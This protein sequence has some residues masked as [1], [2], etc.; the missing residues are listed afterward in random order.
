MGGVGEGR[1][2]KDRGGDA[3][4]RAGCGGQES[5]RQHGKSTR[6]EARGLGGGRGRGGDGRAELN[7]L[8][9]ISFSKVWRLQV[10]RIRVWTL[11]TR[12]R[13]EGLGEGEGRGIP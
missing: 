2:G 10:P 12:Y 9:T 13:A 3:P 1:P 4:L 8:K 6:P 5:C 11:R 7:M